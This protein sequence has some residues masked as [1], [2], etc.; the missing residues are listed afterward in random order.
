MLCESGCSIERLK[1]RCKN[2]AASTARLACVSSMLT[3]RRRRRRASDICD[4]NC[5]QKTA[6]SLT[7]DHAMVSLM[8]P[9]HAQRILAEGALAL[10]VTLG[11]GA[12]STCCI[13]SILKNI[14]DNDIFS[15]VALRA[16]AEPIFGIKRKFC[17]RYSRGAA[18]WR[19]VA[20]SGI[21]RKAR[22]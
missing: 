10:S 15:C 2:N 20:K 21:C 4:A 3:M 16:W 18:Q 6:T 22:H 1:E 5:L 12:L 9:S 17:V 13:F 7:L 11:G 19:I 8:L 14:T